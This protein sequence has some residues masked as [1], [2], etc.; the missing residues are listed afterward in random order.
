MWQ[1]HGDAVL[2]SSI[3]EVDKQAPKLDLRKKKDLNVF[4]KIHLSSA[5]MLEAQGLL[6]ALFDA[7]DTKDKPDK[8]TKFRRRIRQALDTKG[9]LPSLRSLADLHSISTN[10]NST[11]EM[12]E[13]ELLDLAYVHRTMSLPSQN[14]YPDAGPELLEPASVS[15][16][17]H[18]QC[19]RRHISMH[20]DVN[21]A[22]K[23]GLSRAVLARLSSKSSYDPS[24]YLESGVGKLLYNCSL[25]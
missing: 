25:R 5:E 21:V 10:P 20:I 22:P 4:P 11:H 3:K 23:E 12:Q 14:Q 19:Q 1:A 16:A 2:D 6:K 18:N 7:A 13:I 8:R 24:L 17:V 9:V 15:M